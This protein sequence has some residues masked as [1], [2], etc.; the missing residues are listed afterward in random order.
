MPTSNAAVWLSALICLLALVA[1]GG[2]LFWSDGGSP[3]AFALV[4]TSID[5]QALPSDVLSCLPRLGPALFM[6]AAGL[7][8]LLVWLGPLLD[9][10]VHGRPPHLLAGY[11]TMVT[12]A[13]DLAIITPATIISGVLILRRVP[14]GNRIAFPLLGIIVMLLPVIVAGTLSQLAA[15]VSFDAGEIVGP[16]SGFAILGL[17]AIWVI[18]ALLRKL[19]I[20]QAYL[21]I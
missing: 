3:F 17:L 10:M 5:L 7:V 20:D 15:G 2:G 18:I 9:A 6:L 19:S 11:T 1:A 4:F 13:L 14:L 8:T 16:I 21:K 12:D